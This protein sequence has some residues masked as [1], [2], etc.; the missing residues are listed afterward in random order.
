MC[1][2]VRSHDREDVELELLLLRC[3]RGQLNALEELVRR[4]ERP[5][6]YFIR[7]IVKD[8]AHAWDALQKTWIRVFADL[9]RVSGKTRRK[10]WLYRVARN[11]ALNHVRDESR[12]RAVQV[13]DTDQLSGIDDSNGFSDED[14]EEVHRALDQLN[15]SDREALTLY[16]IEDLSVEE[17]ADVLGIPAGTVKSRLYFARQ[18]LRTILEKRHG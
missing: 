14:A 3:H 13:T 2:P 18:R 10:A 16:F 1:R 15:L 17:I 11:T 6:F 7:R 9:P 5:L 8:E 12:H 4:F